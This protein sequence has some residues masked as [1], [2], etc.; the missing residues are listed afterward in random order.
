LDFLGEFNLFSVLET[1]I[2]GCST[3]QLYLKVNDVWTGGHQENLSMCGV[4]IN[5]GPASSIWFY[6]K[7]E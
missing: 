3:P 7:E 4:N 6:L 2:I 1:K 5:H